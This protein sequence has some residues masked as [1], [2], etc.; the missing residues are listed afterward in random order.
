MCADEVDEQT[1]NLFIIGHWTSYRTHYPNVFLWIQR[2]KNFRFV[3]YK[4]FSDN[5]LSYASLYTNTSISA[6]SV[7]IYNTLHTE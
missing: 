6:I 5:R 3:K 1:H 4:P 7:Q 2:H